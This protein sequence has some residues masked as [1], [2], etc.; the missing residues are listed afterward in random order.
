[1]KG[2]VC[3]KFNEMTIACTGRVKWRAVFIRES[4]LIELNGRTYIFNC[5]GAG[6]WNILPV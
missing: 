4:F 1:M 3:W 5:F 2:S 6:E